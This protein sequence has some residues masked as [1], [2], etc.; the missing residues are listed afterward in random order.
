MNETP[1]LIVDDEENLLVLLERIL[2][3][4]GFLV[5]TAHDSQRALE[6]LG[7]NAF[8]AAVL[9]I[10]MFPIDGVTLLGMI[11]ARA[12]QIRVVMITA[13][14]TADSRAEAIQKGAAAYLTKPLDITE[15]KRVLRELTV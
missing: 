9:D 8:R 3:K 14:P 6:L 7:A 10:K 5:R 11:K 12:P 4:E 2:S 15:L 1:I 13:Y